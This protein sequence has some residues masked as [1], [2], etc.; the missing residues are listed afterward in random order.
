[1]H[2]SLLK[3][4]VHKAFIA[5]ELTNLNTFQTNV[6]ITV[7]GTTN[8]NRFNISNWEYYRKKLLE[9]PQLNALVS[10][11]D[12]FAFSMR[13]IIKNEI[14]KNNLYLHF[15]QILQLFFLIII[16]KKKKD[17]SFK[18]FRLKKS[19]NFFLHSKVLF[20][21]KCLVLIFA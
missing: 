9:M 18:I 16:V 14:I 13:I 3:Y 21:K 19:K 12:F 2:T 7:L 10:F 8:F 1:M 6:L 5:E 20:I 15:S 11:L 4:I 17:E